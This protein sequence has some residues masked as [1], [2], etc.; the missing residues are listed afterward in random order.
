MATLTSILVT[1]SDT[2][3]LPALSKDYLPNT[4]AGDIQKVL[5]SFTI[6]NPPNGTD[7]ATLNIVKRILDDKG[8][9]HDIEPYQI[10]IPMIPSVLQE[11]LYDVDLST[12]S[13]IGKIPAGTAFAD[14]MRSITDLFITADMLHEE[15]KSMGVLVEVLEEPEV[16][17]EQTGS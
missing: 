9:E 5:R 10:V 7:T 13:I 15:G 12:V 17:G 1:T 6:H 16:T 11:H 14:T 8:V 2:D 3:N 4:K